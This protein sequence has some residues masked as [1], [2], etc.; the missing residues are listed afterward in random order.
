MERGCGTGVLTM[1]V[2][3]RYRGVEYTKTI[4]D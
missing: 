1:T 3:L 2:K 4:K